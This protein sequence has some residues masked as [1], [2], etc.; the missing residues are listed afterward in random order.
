MALLALKVPAE[1]ST[2]EDQPS[3]YGVLLSISDD[4]RGFDPAQVPH[5]RLGLENMQERAQA[6]GADL[7]IE[8]QPGQGT[9]VTVLW[10][11]RL[12]SQVI[13]RKPAASRL[14]TTY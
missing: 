9:Q 2:P 5:D 10:G 12:K 14:N 8:S 7:T 4:G 1:A 3:R 6:I 13:Q 11:R